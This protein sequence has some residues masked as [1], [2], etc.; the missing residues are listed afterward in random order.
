MHVSEL[1]LREFPCNRCGECCKQVGSADE[2]RFLDRGDGTCRYFDDAANACSIYDQR[3]LVC[4]VDAY[5]AT[6][7]VHLVSW[8]D[9]VEA[10]L[11]VCAALA[12]KS[13]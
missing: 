9:F 4:R 13:K 3:P 7:Y 12:S 5:Y 6:H 8:D 2:T 1:T 10:N 11:R